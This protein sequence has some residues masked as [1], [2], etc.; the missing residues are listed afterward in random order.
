V[1]KSTVFQ[2]NKNQKVFLCRLHN[3]QCG[4]EGKTEEIITQDISGLINLQTDI[5]SFSTDDL[6]LKEHHVDT[7]SASFTYQNADKRLRIQ[8]TWQLCNQTGIW[9]R[10]DSLHNDGIKDIYLSRYLGRYVFTP[11]NYDIFSQ[12]SSWCDENQGIWRP[13]HHGTVTLKNEGGRTTQGGTPYLCLR[14]KD[15]GKGI[16]FHILP[17]GNWVI[18]ISSY[19]VGGYSAP[20]I[21]VELGLA[22]EQLNLKISAGEAVDLPE[23][24]T[25]PLTEGSVEKE[26]P[27]FQ[28]YLL[29]NYF[30]S[31]K[32]SAPVVYN[33]WFDTYEHLEVER[34]RLQLAAAKKLG[35]EVFMVDAGWYGAMKGGW[36][37]QVGDWREKEVA[38]FKG[39]MLDFAEEVRRAGLGFGVWMEPERNFPTV[40]AVKDHPDWFLSG[41]YGFNYP[42]L[43]KKEAYNYI[44]SEMS[45]L[46]ETYKLVWMKIDFNFKLGV[47]PYKS[48]FFHY[49]TKWYELLDELRGKYSDVFFE[50][51]AAGGLR[52]DNSTLSHFDGHLLTDNMN[53]WNV[54]RIYQ[55]ALLRL[56]PGRMVKWTVLQSVG[57]AIIPYGSTADNA[58]ISFVTPASGSSSGTWKN[59][60]T[61]DID[62][63]VRVVLPGQLGFSGDIAGLPEEAKE[64]LLYHV[65][66]YKKWREFISGSV[67][68]LHTPVTHKDDRT[69]WAAIQLSNPNRKES[70]LFVYRL[71]DSSGERTFYPCGLDSEKTYA[72]TVEYKTRIKLKS[73]TGLQ[74]STGGVTIHIPE[75]DNSLIYIFEPEETIQ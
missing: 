62:F 9:S 51:C 11:G 14:N 34:L 30:K 71:D 5:G 36:S 64:R 16:I 54:L 69:G 32:P 24:L 47:D 28:H 41:N 19:T 57:Q 23:I 56:L 29:N 6:S 74:L 21:V 52:Q 63:A 60:E 58:P 2:I 38:A 17:H 20:F 27:V 26:A 68:Y 48:E 49:Y 40:P 65:E 75:R 42:D 44:L 59:S 50:G 18:K 37:L 25:Q 72:I 53:P 7:D 43:T 39:K 70:L 15:N 22:D 61:V 3:L 35:C 46:V 33:T 12:G 10:K 66:F 4:F 67:S 1:Y 31:A 73:L 45:R 55:Q 13:M 8:S